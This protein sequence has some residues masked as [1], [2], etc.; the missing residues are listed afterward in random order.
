MTADPTPTQ[1]TGLVLHRSADESIDELAAYLGVGEQVAEM[2]KIQ[3][4][5]SQHFLDLTS[6][7]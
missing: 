3:P 1:L 5:D 6:V 4:S 7:G 2:T